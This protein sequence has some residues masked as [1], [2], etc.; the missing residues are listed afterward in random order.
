MEARAPR[1][2]RRYFAE[3]PDPRMARTRYHGLSDILTLASVP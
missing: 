2:L 1:G 3:L